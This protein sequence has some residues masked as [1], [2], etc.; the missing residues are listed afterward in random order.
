MLTEAALYYR[1]F[2]GT[3]HP[4]NS[5][6][7]NLPILSRVNFDGES[8]YVPQGTE[9]KRQNALRSVS[10]IL[11]LTQDNSSK[12]AL[13]KWVARV[14]QKEAKRIRDE[15][16][17]AG[18]AIHAYLHSYLTGGKIKPVSKSYEFYLEALNTL[19]PNFGD[20]LLSEQFVV[21]FKYQYL[22]KIDQ[23]GFYREN[24]TLSDLK[25]SLKPKLSIDWVQDKILQLAA[26]YIP[27][28]TLYPV[29]QA[30]LIYLIRDGSY[31]E[32]LFTPHQMEFYKELWLERLSQVNEMTSSAA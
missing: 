12:E 19:L 29:E 16:I 27:I 23:L 21:S 15:A 17:G 2:D 26:Y 30:V 32:F 10:N 9:V 25:T 4:L 11:K 13:R 31:N 1:H 14:G 3:L 5:S 24:L 20:T 18:N 22:G 7:K 28:E 8:Y 6:E